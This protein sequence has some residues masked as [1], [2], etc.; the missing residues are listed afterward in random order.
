MKTLGI[1][2]ALVIALVGCGEGTVEGEGGDV[3]VDAGP[4]GSDAAPIE[5]AG[6][7]GPTTG[8]AD[9]GTA[10]VPPDA[11][12][13]LGEPFFR[14]DFESGDLSATNEAGFRWGNTNRTSIVRD[15]G[16]VVFNGDPIMD[17]PHLDRQW[18]ARSGS[19]SL[20]FRY[21]AYESFSEQRFRMG[22]AYPV[23]WIGYWLRIPINFKHEKV[24]TTPTNNKFF[25][26]WMDDYS[27]HGDGP[28]VVWNF[29][30]DDDTFGSRHTIS[31]SN[32]TNGVRGH[33]SSYPGFIE[34]P[35][36]QGRWMHVVLYARMSTDATS[37]DGE[38]KIWRRWED[39][40]SYTLISESLD[41]GFVAPAA[42]PNGW[43]AG[44]VM[45]WANSGY[46]EDTEFLL[47]DFELAEDDIWGVE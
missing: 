44:Y 13:R 31:L 12:A 34:H 43:A 45:G 15:D 6:D 11:G 35:A 22:A 5:P 19:H 42:G 26:L 16:Y 30:Q 4:P 24:L 37:N 46:A 14:D 25:A 27:Q 10:V 20:R 36:D 17:G 18:E 3:D 21:P 33:H 29:W 7:A 1:A 40:T 2:V 28:T 47:D 39:D 23:I 8:D 9:S 32:E 41:R 38:A